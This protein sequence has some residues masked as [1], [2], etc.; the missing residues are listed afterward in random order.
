MAIEGPLRELALGDVFQLLEISRKTGV[1]TVQVEGRDR[2][3]IV[4]FD[5]GAVVGAQMPD[6]EGRL[7]HLL[8]RSGKMSETGM[9]RVLREQK[10]SPDIPFGTLAVRL[11]MA[12]DAEIR[13]QLAYL[14]EETVFELFRCTDGYFRFDEGPPQRDGVVPVRIPAQSLLLEAARRTDE[15]ATL[16]A[17]IPHPGVVPVLEEEDGA[18]APLDLRPQDWEILAEIDGERTLKQIAID[19]GRSDLEIARTVYELLGCR[20]VTIAEAVRNRP[21]RDGATSRAASTNDA[22]RARSAGERLIEQ[23]RWSEAVEAMALAVRLDPLD[24]AAQFFLGVASARVGDLRRAEQAWK[25]FLRLHDA[26]GPRVHIARRALSAA[27]QLRGV[28]DEA[29]E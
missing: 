1:L 29:A 20:V 11:G 21:R 8:L 16:A 19:L 26:R 9:E 22:G 5:R 15:W 12:T 28:L 25:T 23:R 6:V 18:T 4:R 7:G 2:A 17:R 27:A 24:G 3:A 10:E 14:I 13:R